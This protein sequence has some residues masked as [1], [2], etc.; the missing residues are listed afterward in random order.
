MTPSSV[1]GTQSPL[2]R[3]AWRS[4]RGRAA[5]SFAV[6]ALVLTAAMAIGV[7]ATVSQFLMLQRE[8]STVAQA[9]SNA[10]QVERGLA[11]QGASPPEQLSRLSRE[12]GSTSLL[13]DDG[14]WHTTSLQFGRDD[15]PGDLRRTVL[16]GQASR[17]R[18]GVDQETMLA[19]GVPLDEGA[20]YFEVFPVV[21]LN[22]TLRT[23][24]L[25]LVGAT[26]IVPM[27]ALALGWWATRPALRPLSRLSDAAAAIADGALDTRIDPRG[28][29]EL[30]PIARS[31]NETAAAL[32]RR[33]RADA[34]FA[35]DVAHE[36]RSPLTTMLSAV[37]LVDEY[38]ERL[39][40]GGR[41]ALDLLASEVQRFARLVQDLLEISR[42]DAGSTVLD[43]SDVN[44]SDLVQWALPASL[45]SRLT[46][47]DDARDLHVRV[48]KRRLERVVANLVEN[49]E[50]H[51]VGLTGI[52]VS[53]GDGH[54]QVVVDDAGPGVRESDRQRIFERF[55]RGRGSSRVASDGAG[56]GL[57]LVA[58][59]VHLLG[60]DVTVQESPD[61]GARF[62]LTLPVEER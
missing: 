27:L 1:P 60:G 43:L 6:L 5:I 28:D 2:S 25:V 30:I 59:H 49:A 35:A 22:R 62:V 15:L 23:L 7:W 13:V 38:R 37:A 58:R 10:Q 4:L 3:G 48:D 41:E 51:G 16:D 53:R 18:I 17:Q 24:G 29:P 61:G 52:A 47:A 46:V 33:V 8:R 11:I 12:I 50:T 44:L 9:V 56:L 32:E 14:R 20:A 45:R 39:P 55:A 42:T 57:S 26:L 21:E 40:D 54:A 19:V 31:F 34:R 36:L